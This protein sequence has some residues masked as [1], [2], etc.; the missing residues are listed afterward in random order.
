MVTRIT[1]GGFLVCK[2]SVLLMKR[3]LHKKLAAG[4]WANPNADGVYVVAV[5]ADDDAATILPL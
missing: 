4:C 2:N 1:S 5:N 3:G